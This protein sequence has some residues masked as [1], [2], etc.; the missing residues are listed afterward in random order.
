MK[1]SKLPDNAFKSPITSRAQA[2]CSHSLTRKPRAFR[3]PLNSAGLERKHAP[4]PL[5]AMAHLRSL[6]I[7]ASLSD[8]ED[9][10]GF[11]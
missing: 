8:Q 6:F 4:P 3:L 11:N 9:R 1:D 5:S 2:L 7:Q 10:G